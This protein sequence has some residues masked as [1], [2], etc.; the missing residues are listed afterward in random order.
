MADDPTVL[1]P[2]LE[3][4]VSILIAINCFFVGNYKL[5]NDTWS[6]IVSLL[7]NVR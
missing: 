7:E 1:E 6:V 5:K 4:L 2:Y 3:N